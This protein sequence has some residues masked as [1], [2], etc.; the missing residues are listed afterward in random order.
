MQIKLDICFF[1]VLD[2][3]FLLRYSSL[4]EIG[5]RLAEWLRRQGHLG[6]MQC[7]FSAQ[8]RVS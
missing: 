8:S 7:D 1:F 5:H 2:N 4:S 6:T 3:L